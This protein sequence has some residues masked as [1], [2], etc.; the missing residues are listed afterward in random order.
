MG[1]TKKNTNVRSRRK[2][3]KEWISEGFS[4]VGFFCL[5]IFDIFE[6]LYSSVCIFWQ[7]L[8][9]HQW[10]VKIHDNSRT[11]RNAYVNRCARENLTPGLLTVPPDLQAMRPTKP[12]CTQ[13]AKSLQ[14]LMSSEKSVEVMDFRATKLDG[15]LMRI[16]KTI[17]T[18]T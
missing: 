11:T 13:K 9:G 6:P 8:D 5:G 3:T 1:K 2:L 15:K 18:I 16:V 7:R 12:L 4:C 14:T 10:Q 17:C